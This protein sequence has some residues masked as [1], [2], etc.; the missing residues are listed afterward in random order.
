MT[1]LEFLKAHANYQGDDC[2][3]WHLFRD[4]N[5]YG[6]VGIPKGFKG[7]TRTRVRWAHRIICEIAHGPPPSDTHEASHSC[8]RGKHGCINPRHL[9]WKT[10]SE[11]QRERRKHGTHGKGVGLPRWRLTPEQVSQ[12]RAFGPHL[13]QVE[14]R[15]RHSKAPSHTSGVSLVTK[16]TEGCW[17]D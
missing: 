8:G 11:N 10:P 6:R 1:G 12:I 3:I 4:H 2:L 15:N 5:G 7:S 13:T 14:N 16:V 9:S 17:K